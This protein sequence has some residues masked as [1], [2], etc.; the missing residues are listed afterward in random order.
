[1]IC[2][3]TQ[4]IEAGVDIDFGAVIRALAGLDSIA[5]SAGRCNRHGVREGLG[6]VWVVNPQEENLDRLPDIKTGREKVQTVLDDFRSDA[7]RFDGDRI[8]LQAIA[9]YYRYYFKVKE[10]DMDYPVDRNSRVGQD[11][12]LYNVLSSNKIALGEYLRI[13]Q[14]QTAPDMLLRQSFQS[15]GKEFQVIGAVTRGVV[16]PYQ[17]GEMVIAELCGAREL[18]KQYRLLKKAQRY[19][20]NLFTHE[21]DKLCR[22]GAIQEVQPEAGIYHLSEQYY[23]EEFGWSHEPVSDMKVSIA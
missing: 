6:S 14:T 7:D 2:V 1:M 16:V 3:S 10:K 5:Q 12:D 18:D 8:G 17:D 20:V 19:S 15:A 4:L 21:F 11:D 9:E 23:S 22:L 13:H